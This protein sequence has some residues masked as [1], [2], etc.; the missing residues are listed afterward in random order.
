MALGVLTFLAVVM[1]S[2][3]S[4]DAVAQP[5]PT[6]TALNAIDRYLST[7][8]PAQEKPTPESSD[9]PSFQPQ[10]LSSFYG[11][12]RA[13]NGGVVI[14]YPSGL[15][16]RACVVAHTAENNGYI[17]S[18][19]QDNF[20]VPSS[21]LF[22]RPQSSYL[23]YIGDSLFFRQDQYLIWGIHDM[24]QHEYLFIPLS[25]AG[26]PTPPELFLP[27][28]DVADAIRYQLLA[29]GCRQ[30]PTAQALSLNLPDRLSNLNLSETQTIDGI[31]VRLD[32]GYESESTF[33]VYVSVVNTT[34]DIFAFFPN[35]I[36]VED[37]QGNRLTARFLSNVDGNTVY[38]G[39]EL[40]GTLTVFAEWANYR[41]PDTA[42]RLIIPEAQSSP[43]NRQFNVLLQ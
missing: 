32:G 15:A 33:D 16:D 7:V 43:R 12:W 36:W 4:I 21:L 24:E 9:A 13:S 11:K 30:S 41:N 20:L 40:S 39:G 23:D 22:R 6:P 28:T 26:S 14:I 5:A 31:S 34:S 35:D 18:S 25:F 10:A 29:A 27:A 38:P 2:V 17:Q 1:F 37:S 3:L 19:L 8:Y 42:L